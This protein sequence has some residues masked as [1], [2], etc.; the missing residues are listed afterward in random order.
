[1]SLDAW[2]VPGP[3]HAVVG[4]CLLLVL[5]QARSRTV[6]RKLR[7]VIMAW[8]LWLWVAST[9]AVGNLW[10]RHL[11]TR[12]PAVALDT[13]TPDAS[14]QII[15]LAS[16]QL[17]RPD[18]SAHPVLDIDGWERLYAGIAAWKQLRG[19]LILV[20][21]PG[22]GET[23]ALAQLMRRVALEAGVPDIAI[24]AIGGTR[25]TREDLQAVHQALQG[26]SGPRWLVT[27]ALHMPRALALALSQGWQ[28]Q[29]LPCAPRHLSSPTWRAWLPDNGAPTLWRS[30]LHEAL[31]LLAGRLW[32][33]TD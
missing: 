20:G 18:G 2:L 8:A 28:P 1:M 14:A 24:L 3:L 12:Y 25:R 17:S 10:V 23:D 15:V 21:G 9:P 30:G 26:T 13:L 33:G 32:G 11:E 16:G 22:H 5:L 7:W 27:S 4:S 19:R 29:P 6:V 31:G